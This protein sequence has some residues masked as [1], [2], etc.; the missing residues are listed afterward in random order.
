MSRVT[1]RLRAAPVICRVLAACA[2]APDALVRARLRDAYP[3]GRR[4][5]RCYR[6]WLDE[7]A[8]QQHRKPRLGAR[9]PP[10]P[11]PRQ[12]SLFA[13]RSVRRLA[14]GA[15]RRRGPLS[16]DPQPKEVHP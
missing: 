1:W 13:K 5:G 16:H 11:D 8:R 14:H 7:I 9:A 3:F 10:P 2:H 15:R 6:V 12:L 4:K